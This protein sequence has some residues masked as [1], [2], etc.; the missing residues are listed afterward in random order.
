MTRFWGYLTPPPAPPLHWQVYYISLCSIVD[1]WIIPLLLA[2][3]CS[4]W[5]SPE[6]KRRICYYQPTTS[7]LTSIFINTNYVWCC[8]CGIYVGT[9]ICTYFTVTVPPKKYFRF[10]TWTTLI[11]RIETSWNCGHINS[12]ICFQSVQS[13][14]PVMSACYCICFGDHK[15]S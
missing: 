9:C 1:I 12:Q 4:L 2:C 6:R 8:W 11:L 13:G 10:I 7:D 5:M 15:P 14:Q 3:Q